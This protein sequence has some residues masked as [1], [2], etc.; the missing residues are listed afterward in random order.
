MRL[1][2]AVIYSDHIP[3][4]APLV[5]SH[6]PPPL[7]SHEPPP[8]FYNMVVSIPSMGL[9][10]HGVPKNVKGC[11]RITMNVYSFHHAEDY[12]TAVSETR[13]QR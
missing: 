5:H 13:R 11:E 4:D 6:E 7:F 3:M 8:L 2:Y 12:C 1:L 10:S 9:V